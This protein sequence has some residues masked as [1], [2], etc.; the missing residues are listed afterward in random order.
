MLA[1]STVTR[2]AG[3]LVR[4][5]C[6]C[7]SSSSI[8]TISYKSAKERIKRYSRL[9]SY[10][11]LQGKRRI[12][13]RCFANFALCLCLLH[14]RRKQIFFLRQTTYF[15]LVIDLYP[16]LIAHSALKTF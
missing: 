14:G 5:K 10:I 7:T 9:E 8:D 13:L 2:L 15:S 1:V 3:A 12:N 4:A 11:D 16:K 6:I